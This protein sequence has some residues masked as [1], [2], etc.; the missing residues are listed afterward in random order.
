MP[1]AS[2][3]AQRALGVFSGQIVTTNSNLLMYDAAANRPISTSNSQYDIT[4]LTSSSPSPLGRG[5]AVPV[6]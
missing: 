6:A 2:L 5:K 3:V 1:V 4:L